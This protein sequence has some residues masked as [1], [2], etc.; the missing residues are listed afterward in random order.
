MFNHLS[1]VWDKVR[2]GLWPVP[3][4]MILLA[5]PLY[6]AAS[7][8]DGMVSDA[9]GLRTWWLHSGSGDDARNLL[10]TLVAAIITMSTLV[11]SITIV[12]LSLAANQF[13]SRLIRT[14]M[15]D[16]RTKLALGVFTMT[17]VYCLLA[18]RSVEKDMP[19]G[20]VPHVVVTLGLVLGVCCVLT[21]LFFLHVV[22]RSIMA[23]EVIRRVADEL[24]ASVEQLPPLQQRRSEPDPAQVLPHDFD[25]RLTILASKQEG[26]VQAVEHARLVELASKHDVVVRLEMRPGTFMCKDGWLA[27]VYP[28]EAVTPDFVEAFQEGF[29]IGTRRT[30]TQDLEFPI[31][32]LVDIA[33]RALSPGINDPN[34]AMVVI[35]YL[36]AALSRL[37]GKCLPPAIHLD[38]AGRARL[39][40]KPNGYDD[41]LAA[42]LQQIRQSAAGHPDVII[43]LLR[44][45][46]R[47]G[48]HVRLPEQRDALLHQARMTADGGLRDLAEPS[49]RADVE[50][51]LA[52]VTR[53]LDQ[54]LRRKPQVASPAPPASACI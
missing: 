30:P 33:L 12:T 39:I 18:L 17:I 48:E 15:T 46:G 38:K 11:F 53:K 26:Y 45:I 44:A 37:M 25:A 31:R 19:P 8:A 36:R 13:G 10:S 47:I 43:T 16:M 41:I 9:E 51:N 2:T 1:V 35:D 49:D 4:S 21:L 7:W 14:Y 27:H 29:L 34:T 23:D 40:D 50:R 6:A 54:V 52:A 3:I 24:E 42:A 32:H 28:A 22:A 5:G 20:V